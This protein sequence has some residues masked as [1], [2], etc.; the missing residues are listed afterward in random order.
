MDNGQYNFKNYTRVLL[1]VKIMME[2]ATPPTDNINTC[3]KSVLFPTPGSPPTNTRE[4]VDKITHHDK[5]R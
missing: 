5:T 1:N 4:P 3:N 2:Q